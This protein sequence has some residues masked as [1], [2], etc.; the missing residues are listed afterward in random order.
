MLRTWQ[1]VCG[2]NEGCEAGATLAE[3]AISFSLLVT[4][5]VGLL[6]FTMA[7]YSYHFVSEV[8]REASR[9]AIV[10]GS[11]SCSN[12]PNL[13]NCN[14]TA[15]EVQSWAR[16]L[17]YPGVNPNNL[18]VSTTWPSSGSS[19]YPSA[20]PCN[21]PGNLVR[22]QVTYAFPLS[23]PFMTADTIDVGSTSQMVISQ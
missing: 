22:V 19:C 21:N 14:V 13:T 18:T 2:Q 15:D 10:R 6:E 23:I 5:M 11:T 8:A 1:N 12:T 17:G 7:L 20:T 3:V 9:Y 16:S 4:I